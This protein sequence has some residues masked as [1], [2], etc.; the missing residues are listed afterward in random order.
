[1]FQRRDS[2]RVILKRNRS[3]KIKQPEDAN[4]LHL[5]LKHQ[6]AKKQGT[7]ANPVVKDAMP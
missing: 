2:Y 3:N 4:T 1:M 7:I 6:T 5:I